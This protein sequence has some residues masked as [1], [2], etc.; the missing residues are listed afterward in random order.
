MLAGSSVDGARKMV[1]IV[2]E[3]TAYLWSVPDWRTDEMYLYLDNREQGIYRNLI[4]ECWV[5]RSIPAEPEMLARFVHEPME[6]FM[7]VWAKISKKF[8]PIHGGERLISPRLEQDRR[9]L[10]LNAKFNEKRA[11]KAAEARWNKSNAEKEIHANSIEV[12]SPEH[13]FEHHHSHS[14]SHAK[15]NIPPSPEDLSTVK[16]GDSAGLKNAVARPRDLAS[17]FYAEKCMEMRNA[18]YVCENADF[19]MLAKLRKGFGTEAREKPPG[20]DDAVTHYLNS[21]LSQYSLADLAN[22]KRY[23]VFV[24][25]PIGDYNKQTNHNGNGNGNG[26][27]EESR[28]ERIARKNRETA[29]LFHRGLADAA[30]DSAGTSPDAGQARSVLPRPR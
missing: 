11:K 14:H 17:D 10:M 6:Y 12:A 5:E 16:K 4:D 1:A 13:A 20:W 22:P 2:A 15:G 7:S 30:G 24:K 9:R 26:K 23:A 29:A 25:S 18:P 19:V 8:K 3:F 28:G 27:H 21:N